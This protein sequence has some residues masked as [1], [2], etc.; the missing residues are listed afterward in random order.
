ML[1]NEHRGAQHQLNSTQMGD[2]MLRI[3]TGGPGH[4]DRRRAL[5]PLH[6]RLVI[7]GVC[8]VGVVVALAA[9]GEQ[10]PAEGPAVDIWSALRYIW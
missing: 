9:R 1:K 10:V 6:R 3:R 2:E 5:G 8:E 7:A 4:R